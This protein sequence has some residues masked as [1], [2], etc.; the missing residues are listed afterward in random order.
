MSLYFDFKA[1]TQPC[2]FTARAGVFMSCTWGLEFD[3][4]GGRGD[5]SSSPTVQPEQGRLSVLQ[6]RQPPRLVSEAVSVKLGFR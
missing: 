5:P 1:G 4:R 6:S 3:P 2:Q